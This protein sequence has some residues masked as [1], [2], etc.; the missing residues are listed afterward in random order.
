MGYLALA[1]SVAVLGAALWIVLHPSTYGTVPLTMA[2]ASL[3]G[4]VLLLSFGVIRL[5]LARDAAAPIAPTD[6][7]AGVPRRGK[8]R[9]NVPRVREPMG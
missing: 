6:P 5:V 8:A 3:T 4:Q 9:A 2:T 7:R 1:A